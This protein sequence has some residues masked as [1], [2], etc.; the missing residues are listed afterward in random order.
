MNGKEP[1]TKADVQ[2]A[3]VQ[4]RSETKADIR[5]AVD[6]L[7]SANKAD[8]KDAVEQLRSEMSHQYHD[9]VERI[10]DSETKLL[11]AFYGF[12]ES[13]QKRVTQIEENQ[14]SV[15]SRLGSLETRIIEVEKRLNMPPA[16]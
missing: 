11:R 12:V 13:N 7:R 16:A 6:Q 15:Q 1:A 10:A 5:E 3:A 2:E 14:H 9:L 8:I 4:L